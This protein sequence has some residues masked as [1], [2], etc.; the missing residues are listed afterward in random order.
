MILILHEYLVYFILFSLIGSVI[1]VFTKRQIFKFIPLI[2]YAL[3]MFFNQHYK[4]RF[5][6]AD[7]ST[8]GEALFIFGGIFYLMGVD[9]E[10]KKKIIL[11]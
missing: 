8:L 2:S 11:T 10:G 6:M 4:S 7:K 3:F 1:I 9:I 5:Q